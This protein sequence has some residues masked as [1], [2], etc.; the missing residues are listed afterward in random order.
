M[1]PSPGVVP[2]RTS[3]ILPAY[4]LGDVL[5]ANLEHV[6]RA[7]RSL[8]DVEIVVVDDGSTDGTLAAATAAAERLG[9]IVVVTHAGNRGK[10]EALVTGWRVSTG[11]RIVF[12]DADLDLPPE[13]AGR[14]LARLADADAVV[15]AKRATMGG[16]S[17]PPLRRLLSRVFALATTG[18]LGLPVAETQ[19]G[20]KAF[21]RPVLDAVLP[22]VRLRGYTFDLEL[23]ARAHDGGFRIVEEPAELGPTASS[24]S[25]RGRMLWELARDT[26]RLV[27]WRLAPDLFDPAASTRPTPRSRRARAR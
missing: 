1:P 27:T 3:V 19:T 16:G 5:D 10:G 12:L 17:Y 8:G 18:L 26:L 21:R 24:A 2:G 13:Q 25:L 14:F 23:V 11:E 4:Q 9:G 7:T 6:W 22:S 15:G 20:I